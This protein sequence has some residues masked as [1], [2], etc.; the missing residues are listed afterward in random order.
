V[1][2]TKEPEIDIFNT[3]V[4]PNPVTLDGSVK[5]KVDNA[6]SI[7]KLLLSDNTGKYILLSIELD[8]QDVLSLDLSNYDL[9]AGVYTLQMFLVNG[10]VKAE[11]LIL[12]D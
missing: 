2:S 9:Y 7:S 1:S 8:S 5:I 10:K 4:Y 6:T 3:A 12:I 11:K